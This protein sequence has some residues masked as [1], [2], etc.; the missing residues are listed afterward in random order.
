MT[1]VG[2]PFST[3]PMKPTLTPPIVWI[4]YGEKSGVACGFALAF[5]FSVALHFAVRCFAF[6]FLHAFFC[7][8][9]VVL[10]LVTA[11]SCAFV[12]STTTFADRYGNFAPT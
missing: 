7:L 12:G 4:E 1:I 2:V 8:A 6:C 10:Y 9:S 3:S 5:F 11:A